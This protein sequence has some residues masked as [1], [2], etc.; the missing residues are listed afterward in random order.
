MG[1]TLPVPVACEV[2]GDKS[3]GKH[4][5][6]YCC[7]GCS[8]FFKRSIRKNI[9]YTCI[10][11]GNCVIDKARRN[12][13]PYCRL[14]KCF[15]VNMNR[16]AVQEERGPRK[17]KGTKRASI[18]ARRSAQHALP[19]PPFGTAP[20][21]SMATRVTPYES[22]VTSLEPGLAWSPVFSAF[23]RVTPRGPTLHPYHPIH[24][25][26][27]WPLPASLPA[28]LFG[29]VTGAADCLSAGAQEPRDV[30]R[31]LR[32]TAHQILLSCLRRTQHNYFFKALHP[33]EQEAQL[34]SHWS[35]VFLLAASYW[36]VDIS[37]IISKLLRVSGSVHDA[38]EDHVLCG[39][40]KVISTCQALNADVTELP[41]LETLI[42]LRQGQREAEVESG[43]LDALQEQVQLALA[44][45]TQHAFVHAHVNTQPSSP[46][47]LTLPSS[48][49]SS[50][51]SSTTVI[52]PSPPPGAVASV[53][54]TTARF[55]RLL[56]VLPALSTVSGE[57]LEKLLFPD[58]CVSHLIRAFFS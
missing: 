36:P 6:V 22:S 15:A 24:P 35:E 5:G 16:N 18:L 37:C 12:W 49:S 27:A 47:S 39:V 14:Q 45:Y 23:R 51:S 31:F 30:Q 29:S 1:R 2:C 21:V 8:C 48:S 40:Q 4:Y 17:N 58:V 7:D 52:V 33:R 25:L 11:K 54:A 55:G 50:S 10:G 41:F 56:L 38:D 9:A 44:H 32:H 20:P 3:Y 34:E 53:V 26:L 43:R 57:M 13:C 42:L 19:A 46:S 28:I